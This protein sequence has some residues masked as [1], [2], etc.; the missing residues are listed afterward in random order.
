MKKRK[1]QQGISISVVLMVLVIITVIVYAVAAQGIANLNF[2]DINKENSLAVYAAEAGISENLVRY[3]QGMSDWRKG[4]GSLQNPTD[5]DNGSAYFVDVFDNQ[6][7]VSDIQAS[8]GTVVPAG[9]C[10]FLGTGLVHKTGP[11]KYKTVKK[12]CV[13]VK[14]A[15][16]GKFPY[17]LASG[18]D[19]R[20]KAGTDIY[21]NIKSSGSIAFEAQCDVVSVKGNGNVFAGG[22]IDVSAILSMDTNQNAKARDYID[23]QSK[24]KNAIVTPYD[25]SN[26]TLP[27]V[28][29]LSTTQ[30]SQ[31]GQTGEV[32]P[33]PNRTTLFGFG[34]IITH[35]E[36]VV[37]GNLALDDAIHYFPNG[38]TFTSGANFTGVGTVLVDNNNPMNFEMGIGSNTNFYKVNLIS[39]EGNKTGSGSAINFKQSAFVNGL[40]YSYG[41]ITTQSNFRVEGSVIAYKGGQVHTGAHGEFSL[42]PIPVECPGFESWLGDGSGQYVVHVLSWQRQ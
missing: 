6:D 18:Q 41:S 12:V 40:V 33:Y 25:K 20:L 38:V 24:I 42:K 13:M 3:K 27:F 1:S 29:D 34:K 28:N 22:H 26:D 32:L 8:D 37:S 23:S 11:H 7:G 36:T 2:V 16:L 31:T 19:I 15:F 35:N 21:G 39:L 5:L 30:T 4:L 10:Y 14:G 17:A 9:L